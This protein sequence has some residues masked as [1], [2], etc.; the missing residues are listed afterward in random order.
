MKIDMIQRLLKFAL[1]VLGVLFIATVLVIGTI[2]WQSYR[3]WLQQSDA[4]PVAFVVEQGSGLSVIADDLK[5][6]NFVSNAFWFKVYAKLDGTARQL[7]AGTFEVRPG[8]SYA[9]IVDELIQAESDEVTITIPEGYTIAQI[10]EV[11]QAQL[12]ITQEDWDL[13]TGAASPLETQH[14]FIARYKPD[15]VDLEGYLFPDTYRFFRDATAED[16]VREMADTLEAR[17]D[18]Q[19]IVPPA[20]MTM[21]ELITLASIIQREVMQPEEMELVSGIFHNRLD[22]GMALQA[23][24]TVNYVTG[25]D[26]PSITLEDRDIDSPY[27]TYLYPGLP[28]GPISSPGLHALESAALPA[29]TAYFYFLTDPE[30]NVYY[31]VTHDEHV[32]NKNTY[33]R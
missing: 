12:A 8:A 18:A 21:H 31:A 7:Q 28:P 6:Q 15:D 11:V 16:V 27:N 14:D 32:A 29:E 23:D 10:G 4:E 19:G 22:I 13:W 17:V 30:G 24:S 26:T 1:S 25:K 9:S 2:V 20:E 3:F 5:H 33:M